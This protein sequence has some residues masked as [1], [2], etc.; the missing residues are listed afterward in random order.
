[1]GTMQDKVVLVTG[2][3]TGIGLA[4]AK[5]LVEEFELTFDNRGDHA[6][7]VLIREH[8]YRGLTWTV[9]YYST[10]DAKKEGPQQIAMR[11]SVPAH[12]HTKVVYV[13]VYTW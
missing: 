11:T 3:A 1:M 2:G 7:S 13:V 9:P 10:D 4:T 6:A 8:L 5:R 12:G